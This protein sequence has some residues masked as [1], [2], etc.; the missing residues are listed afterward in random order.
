MITLDLHYLLRCDRVIYFK[1]GKI[2]EE[3]RPD[4]LALNPN[5]RLYQ[6]IRCLAD[7]NIRSKD[8]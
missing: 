7:A 1:K 5:S 2:Y 4:D 3:G 8:G 6:M